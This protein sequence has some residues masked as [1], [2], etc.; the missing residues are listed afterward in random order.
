MQTVT[1][2]L[3]DK[4]D[5]NTYTMNVDVF[6]SYPFLI[7]TAESDSGYMVIDMQDTYIGQTPTVTM[8]PTDNS[9]SSQSFQLHGIFV[10]RDRNL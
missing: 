2:V 6:D 1:I 4:F 10:V 8:I 5:T 3:Q 9:P 7:S